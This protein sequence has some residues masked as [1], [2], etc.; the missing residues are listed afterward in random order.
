M[1]NHFLSSFLLLLGL[2]VLWCCG[3]LTASAKVE[4][5]HYYILTNVYHGKTLSTGGLSENNSPLSGE[6]LNK[7]NPDQI[8]Q[9]KRSYADAYALYNAEAQLAVDLALQSNKGPLLWTLNV[10]NPNQRLLIEEESGHIRLRAAEDYQTPRYLAITTSGTVMLDTEK[11]RNTLFQITEVDLK[12]LPKR[13]KPEWQD[14]TIFAINKERGRA[15]F[16]PYATTAKLQSDARYQKAWLTP[17]QA[18]YLPLN[19]MWKFQYAPDATLRD[20]AFVKSSFDVS[21][22]D[23][24]EVPSCWEMKGYDKPVYVNVD[25]IF[26]DKPPYIKLKKEYEGQVDPNPVGSYRR[27]FTLPAGWDNQNVFLHFDGIYSGAY[28]WVNGRY[29]GYTQGANN[30]AEFDITKAVTAGENQVAVQVI[31]W[32]D[33]SYLEGQDVFHMSGLH[34][35]VYLVATPKTFVRD[36]VVTAQLDPAQSYTAGSMQVS[37]ELDNRHLLNGTKKI[38]VS[39]LDAAGMVLKTAEK[40]VPFDAAHAQTAVK[41]SL[42]GLTQLKPWTAETPYL[43]NVIVSQQDVEGKEEMAFNTKIRF[44]TH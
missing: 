44:P 4:D 33:G 3:V 17:E 2:G 41:L 38:K 32:T 6:K 18:Q 37:L 36:H 19:G 22:W 1:R 14:E 29:I 42:D 30:D 40:T 15:T 27:T 13:A 31:R 10:N 24:I 35:D 26:Q 39:L 5:G 12:N 9:F 43:Y 34:R 28:V 21:K 25:Y 16:I 11:S 8:W 23:D 7:D 20:T